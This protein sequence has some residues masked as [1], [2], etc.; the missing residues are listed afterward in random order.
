[1]VVSAVLSATDTGESNNFHYP[2]KP[3]RPQKNPTNQANK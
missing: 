3:K 1:M 2:H